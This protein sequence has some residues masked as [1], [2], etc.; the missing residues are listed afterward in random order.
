MNLEEK[1]LINKIE[2]VR[3]TLNSDRIN[4]DS[5]EVLLFSNYLIITS[6]NEDKKYK[7]IYNN[8]VF[9]AIELKKRMIVLSDWKKYGVI[10]IFVGV[11]RDIDELFEQIR[12]CINNSN[13]INENVELN[14]DTNNEKL[15]EEWEKKMVFNDID[16]KKNK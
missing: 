10:N 4:V 9:F 1:D 2:D 12:T 15:L 5:G 11:D 13:N 16:K 7:I 6:K 8:I 3:I 14:E